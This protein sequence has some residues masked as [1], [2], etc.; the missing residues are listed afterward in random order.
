MSIRTIR[1][2]AFG[3]VKADFL[4]AGECCGGRRQ[5]LIGIDRAVLVTTK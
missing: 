5:W 3:S 1:T 2:P 4:R